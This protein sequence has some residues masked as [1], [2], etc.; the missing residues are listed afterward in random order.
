MHFESPWAFLLLLTIPA[1]IRLSSRKRGKGSVRFSSIRNA[2]RAPKSLRQRLAFIPTLLRVLALVLL[3]VALARPQ[4]GLE[5]VRDVNKGI[6]IEMVIDR[7]SS[8]SA[9][10]EYKGERLNRLEV[11]K[12]V[13]HDFVLGG[14]SGLKGRPNDLIGIIAFARYPDTVCP[15]SMAH[16]ALPRFLETVKLVQYK[17]EDGTAI[18]D[19]LALAAARLKTAEDTLAQQT[20]QSG[21]TSYEIKSKIIILLTDGENNVGKRAPLEAAEL[22]KQ[23]GIKIYTIGVGGGESVTTIKTPFGAYKVPTGQGVDEDTLKSVADTTG[24]LY[25]MA[26]TAKALIDVYENIDELERTEIETVRYMDYK[27]KFLPWSLLA[28][29]CICVE[30]GLGATVFRRVP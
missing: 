24:G 28:L 6:A 8:M 13:F 3:T 11:V 16:G 4:E 5:R 23:W 21:N 19:A 15:L 1:V 2:R 20:R 22:A 18:G 17:P 14:K 10:M 26:D 25:R 29:V 12:R 9:E 7:S 27:E 30:V